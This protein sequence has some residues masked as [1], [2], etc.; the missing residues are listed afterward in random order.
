MHTPTH[1]TPAEMRL[2]ELAD[3]LDC[4]VEADLALLADASPSTVEAWRKRGTGPSYILLGRRYMYPRS[5]VA[6]YLQRLVRERTP[7]VKHEL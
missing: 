1:D 4:I 3:S 7:S 5:A 2:R 6:E